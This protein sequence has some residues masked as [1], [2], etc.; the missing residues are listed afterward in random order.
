MQQIIYRWNNALNEK[1]TS[2]LSY[3]Y[4]KILKYYGANMLQSK[5]IFDK[6]KKGQDNLRGSFRPRY[7]VNVIVVHNTK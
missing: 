1:D 5:A 7:R 2:R 4:A 3:L 6:Q